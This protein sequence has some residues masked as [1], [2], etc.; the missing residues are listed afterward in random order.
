M[1]IN[2]KILSERK[3]PSLKGILLVVLM[4]VLVLLVVSFLHSKSFNFMK[5]GKHF[6]CLPLTS[7]LLK[8]T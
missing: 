1:R 7:G 8:S 4:K 2:H 3:V 6:Q 5:E